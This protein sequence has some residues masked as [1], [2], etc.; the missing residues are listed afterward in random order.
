MGV[1]HSY[2]VEAVTESRGEEVGKEGSVN[3]SSDDNPVVHRFD[4]T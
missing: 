3:S 4:L 1:E 2:L